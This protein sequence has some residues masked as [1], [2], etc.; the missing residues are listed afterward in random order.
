MRHGVGADLVG[1]DQG[2]LGQVFKGGTRELAYGWMTPC[3]DQFGPGESNQ[4]I[5]QTGVDQR[6]GESSAAFA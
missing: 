4:I 3:P 5:D 2:K 6:G 1:A